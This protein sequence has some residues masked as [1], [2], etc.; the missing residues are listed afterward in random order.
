MN[1]KPP[2]LRRRSL[3]AVVAT[4]A[5]PTWAASPAASPAVSPALS[6]VLSPVNRSAEGPLVEVWKSPTCGCC[7]DWIQHMQANGFRV[8][9]NEVDNTAPV[10][11]RVGFAEKFGSCHTATVGGYALEGHVPAREVKRLLADKPR[12]VVGIAVPGMPIGSPGMDGPAYGGK[13]DPY[14]VVLVKRD[15]SAAVYQSYR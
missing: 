1:P 14:D 9:V 13:K 5:L 4:L 2:A 15:G 6:P 10:R 7:G 3:L 8:K 12:G 11:K